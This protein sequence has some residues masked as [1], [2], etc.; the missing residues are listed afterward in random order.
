MISTGTV[1]MLTPGG[2]PFNGRWASDD[3]VDKD[4]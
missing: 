2:R 3:L 1:A 4:K